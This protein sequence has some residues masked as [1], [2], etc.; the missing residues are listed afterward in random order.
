MALLSGCLLCGSAGL[1]SAR[2]GT[3]RPIDI[4][5]LAD[6]PRDEI[7]EKFIQ[8]DVFVI[9]HDGRLFAVGALCP[10]KANYLLRDPQD[11]GRIICSGHESTF[12]PEGV[13]THGP[14]RRA[15]ARYAIAVDNRG[16]V[17]VDT[18]REFSQAQWQDEA[19]YLAVK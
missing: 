5:T 8:F 12:D 11:A 13:P 18:S 16:R 6:Y 1:R 17:M 2:A 7:S 19:S 15:L 3:D 10:H 9:R 14:A 4:G